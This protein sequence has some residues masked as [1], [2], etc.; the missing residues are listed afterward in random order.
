[1]RCKSVKNKLPLY[2]SADLNRRTKEK[3][4]AHLKSCP[5]CQQELKSLEEAL[6]R[7]KEADS[8]QSQKI[9]SWDKESW[10]A[11]REKIWRTAVN[12]QAKP[13]Q[14]TKRRRRY[15]LGLAAASCIFLIGLLTYLLTDR[16]GEKSPITNAA[17]QDV[18]MPEIE[19]QPAT[20]QAE[21]NQP[22]KKAKAQA[23]PAELSSGESKTAAE[24]SLRQKQTSTEKRPG[25]TKQIAQTQAPASTGKE[26]S[27]ASDL[28]SEKTSQRPQERIEMAFILPDSGIQI[29][30]IL[31]RN[32]SLEGEKK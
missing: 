28:S 31:D 15:A 29:V 21:V 25:D 23:K 20:I 16:A 14:T 30:W 10:P 24:Q 19:T 7:I 4:E 32:F 22:Q 5:D 2:V 3:I 9:A 26:T 13:A 18:V 11:I 6:R 8:A 17:N 27:Q 1:M 12:R